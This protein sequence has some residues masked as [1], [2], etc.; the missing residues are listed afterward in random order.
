MAADSGLGKREEDGGFS[1]RK[2]RLSMQQMMTAALFSEKVGFSTA[3]S[4]N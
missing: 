3:Y 4:A 2:R 1:W